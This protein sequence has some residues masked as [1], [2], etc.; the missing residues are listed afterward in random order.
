MKI[1][2]IGVLGSICY[3][4]IVF[5]DSEKIESFGGITYNVLTLASLSSH[6]IYP[7]TW[8]G[9]DK[10]SQLF[11]LFEKYP[12]ISTDYIKV[13]SQSTYKVKLNY[14]SKTTRREILL[15]KPHP[16]PLP[17]P[18]PD[19][20]LLLVSFISSQDIPIDKIV[21]LRNNFEKLIY[22]DVHSLVCGGEVDKRIIKC[23][24]I[25]QANEREVRALGISENYEEYGKSLLTGGMKVVIFT[26]GDKGCLVCYDKKCKWVKSQKAKI[27]DVTGAGDTFS[28]A[29]IIKFLETHNPLKSCEFAN[30]I[31]KECCE[32]L[33]IGCNYG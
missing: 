7:I 32:R 1:R 11:S 16:V 33:G 14:I 15:N 28:S 12:N 20:D 6:Q 3:D 10:A 27:V 29:F 22:I 21:Q 13:L 31:A 5:P 9:K 23:C 24:D 17:K 18:F 19:L 30:Q 4:Y 25:L 26:F 8:I 2:K